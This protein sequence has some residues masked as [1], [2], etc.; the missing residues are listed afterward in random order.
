MRERRVRVIDEMMD[1][2]IDGGT[3]K[4]VTHILFLLLILKD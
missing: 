2:W 1:R 3:S 4:V